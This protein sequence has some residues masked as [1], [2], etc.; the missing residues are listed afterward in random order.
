MCPGLIKMTYHLKKMM[1]I[2]G[3]VYTDVPSEPIDLP[4]TRVDYYWGWR[5]L[6][7]MNYKS[8][9]NYLHF[10]IIL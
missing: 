10:L 6:Y 8:Y 1:W 5:Q 7:V 2:G 4:E 9:T 3:Q